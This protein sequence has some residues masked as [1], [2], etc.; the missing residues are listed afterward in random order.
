MRPSLYVRHSVNH[1]LSTIFVLQF[2]NR[3]IILHVDCLCRRLH[4]CSLH[5]SHSFSVL[6]EGNCSLSGSQICTYLQNCPESWLI[7]LLTSFESLFAYIVFCAITSFSSYKASQY[8]CCPDI[9]MFKMYD[10]SCY[11]QVVTTKLSK[12]LKC[13]IA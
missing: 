3:T 13:I 10:A 6:L 4:F 5:T 9:K 11:N 1:S 8:C 2:P 12:V 7:G